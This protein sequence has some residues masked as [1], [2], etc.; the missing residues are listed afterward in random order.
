MSG[1]TRRR[2]SP[3]TRT[4]EFDAKGDRTVQMILVLGTILVTFLGF[5]GI[6]H[7]VVAAYPAV[8]TGKT[9]L[10]PESLSAN[11]GPII[12]APVG[13]QT[14][15]VGKEVV[16]SCSVRNI[17]KYKVAWLRASDQT[18]LTVHTRTV[19][20]NARISIS[21]ETGSNSG[22][23]ATSGA[24]GV[25]G[26][27]QATEEVVNG[28]WRLHIRQLKESDRDCYMCQI[29]T[30]PMK[31]ELGCVDILVPPDIVYGG[32]T[33]ADLAVSEGDNATLSCRATGRPTPRILWKRENN[34][35]IL[36][37]SSSTGGGNTYEKL[38]TYN[39]SQLQFHRVE[40][41]QMGVY[42]CIASNDVPPAVSKR[43]TLAVN[44]APSVTVPNQL[45]GAP[46]GTEVTLKCYVEAFPNTINYWVKNHR[47]TNDEMLLE[48]PKYSV[49]EERSGYKVLMEL[50]IKGFTEQDVGS[51]KCIS[52]NS[53]G[54]ADGTLRLYEIKIGFDR[55]SRGK[56]HVS[57]I[58]GLAEAAQSSGASNASGK[59]PGYTNSLS[60]ILSM[61]LFIPV[62]WPR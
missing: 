22:S 7:T 30:S 33:T 55:T 3:G 9:A 31:S 20:H 25:T 32:D 18:V 46:L 39:G 11:S 47:G 12:V 36:L 5:D 19:T 51:Y 24:F 15:A 40:R 42:L 38:E 48:G 56:E 50:A 28:T 57:I 60:H 41:R 49:R 29:N 17:G 27:S 14:A 8:S 62:L 13:N 58:G 35:P 34:E 52:T 61:F 10:H 54:R 53:L 1:K 6:G 2:C 21:H 43:V 4:V 23:G 26:S 59:V 44:F 16:F 37:R 45:L